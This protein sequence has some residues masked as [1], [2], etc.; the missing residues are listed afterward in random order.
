MRSSDNGMLSSAHQI[1]LHKRG[2]TD[3]TWPFR[4][5]RFSARGNVDR[6][7]N[8]TEG[9]SSFSYDSHLALRGLIRCGFAD[10]FHGSF[11]LRF[12]GCLRHS[13]QQISRDIVSRLR[14]LHMRV[15]YWEGEYSIT[16]QSAKREG[17]GY[18]ECRRHH[19]IHA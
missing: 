5:L 13:D 12:C 2:H 19:V 17:V 7:I 16:S 6:Q 8:G 14:S 1:H 10:G 4:V 15:P 3:N 9:E 11:S 18:T